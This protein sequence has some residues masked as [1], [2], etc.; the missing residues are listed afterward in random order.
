[1]SSKVD[2]RTE[3]LEAHFD[4]NLFVEN[5]LSDVDMEM[6][7]DKAE[8]ER[9]MFLIFDGL[10]RELAIEARKLEDR[11]ELLQETAK[12]SNESLLKDMNA[13]SSKLGKA[14]F[15]SLSYNSALWFY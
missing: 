3:L 8:I 11:V 10:T 2:L 9:K 1:M 6:G 4:S 12:Q 13:H 7:V 15:L 5:Q 14:C